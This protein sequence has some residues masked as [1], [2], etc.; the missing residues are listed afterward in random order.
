[1]LGHTFTGDEQ[2]YAPEAIRR[3]VKT[4]S[5]EQRCIAATLPFLPAFPDSGLLICRQQDATD[6]SLART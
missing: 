5:I 6:F 3:D 2:Q 4:Q 1:V